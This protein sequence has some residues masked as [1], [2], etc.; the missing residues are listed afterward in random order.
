MWSGVGVGLGW[1]ERERAPRVTAGGEPPLRGRRGPRLGSGRSRRRRRLSEPLRASE[2]AL[3]SAEGLGGGSAVAAG[4]GAEGG[5]EAG[6]LLSRAD[7]AFLASLGVCGRR[8]GR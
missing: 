8:R 7:G 1:G 2:P 5:W 6:C 3:G 4:S